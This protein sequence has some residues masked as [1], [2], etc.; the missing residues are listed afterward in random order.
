MSPI[1]HRTLLASAIALTA[2]T[3]AHAEDVITL[4]QLVVTASGFE[5]KLTD[6]PASISVISQQDLQE[7][8]YNSLAHALGDVEGIDIGQGTGKT[9]GRQGRVSARHAG[10]V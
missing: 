4:D 2:A 9:G 3:A 8:R 6:A 7:K 1:R 5:Q 10:A